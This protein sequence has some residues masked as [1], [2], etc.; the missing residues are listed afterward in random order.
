MQ[1]N[2]FELTNNKSQQTFRYFP[3]FAE[4]APSSARSPGNSGSLRVVAWWTK[5]HASPWKAY[6]WD[7]PDHQRG[8]EVLRQNAIEIPTIPRRAL[9]LSTIIFP[10][11]HCPDIAGCMCTK[12]AGLLESGFRKDASRTQFRGLSGI[13]TPFLLKKSWRST[14][15]HLKTGDFFSN[16]FTAR[17]EH[18]TSIKYI[19]LHCFSLA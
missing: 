14:D 6:S 12:Y 5:I 1:I 19:Y 10:Q 13:I 3:P 4:I 7:Q 15:S 11:N 17:S 18:R 8:P 16:C 9:R 2:K